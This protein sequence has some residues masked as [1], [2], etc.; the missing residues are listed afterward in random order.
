MIVLLP[1]LRPALIVGIAARIRLTAFVAAVVARHAFTF[2]EDSNLPASVK[3]APSVT[4]SQ[5][6]SH[7]GGRTI[8]FAELVLRGYA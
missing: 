1:S 6:S 5:A 4:T 2:A 3:N 8:F 7:E